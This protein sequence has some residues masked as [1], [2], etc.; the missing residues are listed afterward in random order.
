[1]SEK[2]RSTTIHSKNK[3]E[4]AQLQMVSQDALPFADDIPF[5]LGELV[6]D[7]SEPDTAWP[8][9]SME[10]LLVN[11]GE[12]PLA[13]QS[14]WVS[15]ASG[16]SYSAEAVAQTEGKVIVAEEVSLENAL[17]AE[18]NAGAPLWNPWWLSSLLPLGAAALVLNHNREQNQD[19][20]VQP[21]EVVN[22]AELQENATNNPSTVA[23]A[24]NEVEPQF[25]SQPSIGG[26]PAADAA[27][28]IR[29][30]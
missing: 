19:D 18:A 20:S 26:Q 9:A 6:S 27:L 17:N 22:I 5:D 24:V 29:N 2:I 1:M 10:T 21:H 13:D 7:L 11:G 23:D 15:D 12:A 14:V 4:A 30:L 25:A 16:G 8:L 28:R 3:I